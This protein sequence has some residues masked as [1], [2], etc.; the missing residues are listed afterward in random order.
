MLKFKV[1]VI[2]FS[3]LL[4]VLKRIFL[5]DLMEPGTRLPKKNLQIREEVCQRL[6]QRIEGCT[7]LAGVLFMLR[8]WVPNDLKSKEEVQLI[9]MRALYMLH[10]DRAVN[11]TLLEQVE[12]FDKILL[13]NFWMQAEHDIRECHESMMTP[14]ARPLL[15]GRVHQHK[16]WDF[17]P[18]LKLMSA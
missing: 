11:H 16:K 17:P 13:I 10:P 9:S 18:W 1:W 2:C 5:L 15:G 14:V 8:F 12:A 3:F 6:N 4:I 7:N